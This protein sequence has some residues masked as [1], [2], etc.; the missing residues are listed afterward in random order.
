[1]ITHEGQ[2]AGIV[3]MV[4]AAL[5]LPIARKTGATWLAIIGGLILVFGLFALISDLVT[6]IQYYRHRGRSRRKQDSEKHDDVA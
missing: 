2:I 6:T 1:M 3:C 5:I 4:I